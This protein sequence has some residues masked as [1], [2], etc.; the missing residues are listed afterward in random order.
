EA[1]LRSFDR[2]WDRSGLRL[3][4]YGTAVF[5]ALLLSY[6]YLPLEMARPTGALL[7]LVVTLGAGN[8]GVRVAVPAAA[9]VVPAAAPAAAAPGSAAASAVP[10]TAS[11]QKSVLSSA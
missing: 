6:R 3:V 11:H 8:P 5:A 10:A 2:G 7:L 9:G 4:A 1:A